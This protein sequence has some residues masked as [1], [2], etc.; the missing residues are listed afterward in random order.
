[1][2]DESP[3]TSSELSEVKEHD[4][5]VTKEAQEA[6]EDVSVIHELAVYKLKIHSHSIFFWYLNVC[7]LCKI[8]RF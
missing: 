6:Q 4:I 3:V 8:G 7:F 1:M 5:R 2:N